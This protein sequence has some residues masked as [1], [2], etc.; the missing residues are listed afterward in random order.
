MKQFTHLHLHTHYSL[1]DG[2]SRMPELMDRA[3]ELGFAAIGLTDHGVLYG[4]IEFYEEARSRGIKPII[5]CEVYVATRSRFD[6]EPKQDDRQYHLTLLAKDNQG[7]SNLVKLATQAQLEGFYYKPRVDHELLEQYH[8]G[9]ICLSGCPS[10]EIPRALQDGNEEKAR[11]LALRYR[12]LFGPENFYIEIQDHDMDW[13]RE[14]TGKLVKLARELDLPLVATNDGHYTRREDAEAHDVLLCIQTNSNVNDANR[15]RMET[16]EFHLR[17]ADE[18]WERFAELPEALTN[19]M[20]IA[21]ACNVELALDQRILP[22]FE[23]PAGHDERSYLH[24]ICTAGLEKLYPDPDAAARERLECELDVIGDMGFSSYLLIAADFVNWAKEQGIPTTVRGSAAGSLVCYTAGITDIDPLHYGLI[25]ERFLNPSRYTMPDIDVDLMDVRRDEVIN[26]VT[27]KYGADHVA[28]IITFGTMKAR[29]AVRDVGRALGM[30]Y[31]EVDRVAKLVPIMSSVGE[32]LQAAPDLKNLMEDDPQVKRLLG[33]AERLEG[34]ARHASTH[35]AGVVIS[36]EP[37]TE[38]VPLQRNV[39]DDGVM[40]QFEMNAIEKIGLL[41]M[42]F[43]GLRNLTVLDRAVRFIAETRGEAIDLKKIPVDDQKTF[44]LLSSGETTGIFQLESDGMRRCVKELQPGRIEDVMA[45]VALYRPGPMAYIPQ[46]VARRHGREKTTA[47]HPLMSAVLERTYGIMVYQEDVMAVAQAVAGYTLAEAD[48]LCYAVR[49]KIAREL[50]EHR[51]RFVQGAVENG[52]AKNLAE[53]IFDDFEPF[54][55]YGFN[56]AHATCYG[57]IAY[58]TAYLKANYPTEYM[59]AVLSTELGNTDKIIEAVRECSRLDVTVA[60]PN[61][62]ESESNF[63]IKEDAIYFGL[64]AVKNVGTAAAEGIAAARAQESYQDFYDFCLRIDQRVVN[65]RALESLIKVGAIDGMGERAAMLA[66]LDDV[67]AS[68]QK[69]QSISNQ[70]PTLFETFLGE[71]QAAMLT[72]FTLPETEPATPEEKGIWEKELLGDYLSENPFK[73]HSAQLRAA[74]DTS[75]AEITRDREGQRVTLAGRVES[76]RRIFTRKGQNMAVLTLE[77]EK[78]HIDVTVFPKLYAERAALLVNGN[79]IVVRGRIEQDSRDDVL[80]ILAESVRPLDDATAGQPDNAQP[81][82]ENGAQAAT[83]SVGVEHSPSTREDGLP[84]WVLDG[85]EGSDE[86]PAAVDGPEA[87]EGAGVEVAAASSP[88]ALPQ[89]NDGASEPESQP[90]EEPAELTGPAV[91]L[92]VQRTPD[93]A[94]DLGQLQRLAGVVMRNPGDTRVAL[95]IILNGTNVRIETH[96]RI[97]LTPAVEDEIETLLGTAPI[98]ET[99][100]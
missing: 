29:A 65:R 5:G 14:V 76:V 49:K 53:E 62:N 52:V 19:T 2:M 78:G 82:T 89:E 51:D 94:Q 35:A 44:D 32:A 38:Y 91:E 59:T 43:L 23:V 81:A 17:S 22:H 100:A 36:R 31:G 9:L 56:Q 6:K 26:Y 3:K 57:T 25:F 61:V 54:A 84:D 24:E 16:E 95:R 42:D 71:E 63:A 83:A 88:A 45:L 73:A 34:V 75:T 85:N 27:E 60:P 12:D 70:G 28:Q 98:R 67:L 8:E 47:R 99:D 66:S 96:D 87:V 50:Q 86:A 68:T 7:Y 30:T 37:L 11:E 90:A 77:D 33:L 79:F 69:A 40:T 21:E 80:R 41:K 10:G 97:S 48:K 72:S 93:D 1:L 20:K 18:M 15:M 39:G 55:R 4:A 46:Y 74:A 13:E 58:Q 92:V 64:A